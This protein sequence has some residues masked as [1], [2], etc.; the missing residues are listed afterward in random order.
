MDARASRFLALLSALVIALASFGS[1]ALMAPRPQAEDPGLA[2]FLAAG[3]DASAI[4]GPV[5]QAA[6]HHCPF[7]RL[8]ADPPFPGPVRPGL[9]LAPRDAYRLPPARIAP[10]QAGNPRIS[11]R[12]PP[13][14]LV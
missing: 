8:L 9:A 3:G 5:D 1:A 11:P 13:T 7:C 10:R 2:A 14:R 4:C 6:D 12:G